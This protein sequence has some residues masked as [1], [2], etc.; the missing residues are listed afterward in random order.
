MKNILLIV[1]DTLRP[2]HLGCYGYDRPTSP[3]LDA[4]AENS[5][6]LESLWSASN[7]TAPA[8]TS[9]FTGLY[10]HQH[11]VFDFTAQAPKSPVFDLFQHNKTKTGG[12]VTFRFFQNLLRQIWGDIEAVTDTRSFDYSK[13]LPRA[14]TESS[15]AWLE[16]NGKS[17][18][19]CL[20]AH[21]DGPHFPFR[22]PDE[23][24][25]VFD[26]VN[27]DLVDPAFISHF[28]PQEHEKLGDGSGST[29]GSRF[30]LVE[31]IN[32]KKR[33]V[34]PET[35]QWNID[36]YDASILYNDRA[37]GDLLEGVTELGLADDTIV[38]VLSDHGEEFLEH[39]A[40]SHGGIHLHEEVIRTVGIIHE[41]GGPAGARVTRPLSQ[42][43]VFPT[44]L[45]MAG[46]EGI[47]E[48]W[49]RPSMLAMQQQ[50]DAVFV[51]TSW[52]G[53]Q[54]FA[55]EERDKAWFAT[56]K[57][58]RYLEKAAEAL[59]K[60]DQE[61]RDRVARGEAP[62][63]LSRNDKR[64]LVNTYFHGTEL[65][66]EPEFYYHTPEEYIK[67]MLELREQNRPKTVQLKSGLRSKK[68]GRA[69]FSYNVI[70]FVRAGEDA[71]SRR[72]RVS[73]EKFKKMTGYF[74]G[75]YR[76]IKGLEAIKS[77]IQ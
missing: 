74:N 75:D 47:S 11:G 38:V 27:P 10:P 22:L 63:V 30:D 12:V 33:K 57:G 15:L 5:T 20:F 58:Q 32:W 1:V 48:S 7:F 4:L 59:K 55:M 9:L 72:N 54:R 60:Y 51:L 40:F 14:V 18:P 46:A 45:E 73:L 36:K 52:W 62:R 66:P 65:P 41:P 19:F 29:S 68:G 35:I 69:E 39:G 76:E 77:S 17:G 61:C 53:Y 37:I 21:Y 24:A 26:T 42:V 71:D 16:E 13:D 64:L 8:F 44:L 70:R 28:F 49:H 3:C 6:V 50:A 34:S 2:D 31:E 56:S 25:H 43:D 23:Y 67:P